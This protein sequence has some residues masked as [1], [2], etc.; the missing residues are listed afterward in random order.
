[1]QGRILVSDEKVDLNYK[2]KD[3][4][5]LHTQFIVMSLLWLSRHLMES[6]AARDGR[7]DCRQQAWNTTSASMWWISYEFAITHSRSTLWKAIQ[8]QPARSTDVWTSIARENICS[9]TAA[10][11]MHN[12]KRFV[13][14]SLPGSCQGQI[15]FKL[16]CRSEQVENNQKLAC[17]NGEWLQGNDVA[18]AGGSRNVKNKDKG[19]DAK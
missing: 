15:S 9:R 17:S 10:W 14:E 16:S 5:Y 4:T 12:A 2:I 7:F 11:Q 3:G 1:M 13:P 6:N 19:G 8:H 18:E